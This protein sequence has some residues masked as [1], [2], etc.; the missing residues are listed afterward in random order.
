MFSAIPS[1]EQLANALTVQKE[2]NKEKLM[3]KKESYEKIGSEFAALY[4]EAMIAAITK[5]V[6]TFTGFCTRVNV[7][8]YFTMTDEDE[9]EHRIP[10]DIVHYGGKR[11]INP[12]TQ[13]QSWYHREKNQFFEGLF[14]KLQKT[15]LQERGYYLLDISDPR[16]SFDLVIKLYLAKPKWYDESQLLWH[17]YNKV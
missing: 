13:R 12:V 8:T 1:A 14:K 15:I 6:G 4:E 9:H 7:P 11:M 5:A 17:E 2:N 10:F 3:L 16:M